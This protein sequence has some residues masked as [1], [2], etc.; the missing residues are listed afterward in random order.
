MPEAAVDTASLC[1]SRHCVS[2]LLALPI[3]GSTT[4]AGA[5][6]KGGLPLDIIAD[7]FAAIHGSWTMEAPPAADTTAEAVPSTAAAESSAAAASSADSAATAAPAAS[8]SSRGPT[9]SELLHLLTLLYALTT[10]SSFSI[11]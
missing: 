4:A 9:P 11:S 5:L 2:Y 10:M 3:H 7:V 6:L 8:A 1:L